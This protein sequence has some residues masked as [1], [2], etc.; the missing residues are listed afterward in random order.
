MMNATAAPAVSV[1]VR[2]TRASRDL[3][4]TLSSVHAQTFA[5]FEIIVVEDAGSAAKAR[6]SGMEQSRGRFLAFLDA[7]DLWTIDFL[8]R[9]VA[10][11]DAHPWCDAVYSDANLCGNTPLTGRRFTDVAPSAGR[12]A[13][14]ALIEGRCA[15]LLS[16]VVARR[17]AIARANGF[18]ASLDHGDDF[19][20]WLRIVN[21]GGRV[22]YQRF[23]LAESWVA[24][25]DP[26][27]DLQET[28]GVLEHF[29]AAH[30]LSAEV[31]RALRTRTVALLD[32]L[33]IE[34]A[35]R[36]FL[37]ANF[38][39]ARY[40]LAAP[41]GRSLRLSLALLALRAAPRVTR[42]MVVTVRMP[43]WRF[44]SANR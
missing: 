19:D 10:Y 12:P 20:L 14:T 40:H 13:L 44:A 37:D 3:D 16:T 43:A 6:N 15:I 8:D 41:R 29:G 35:K 11:L 25:S 7:G 39:A 24:P 32:R 42:W 1:I 28:L 9:Q 4:A 36:C 33:D 18:D 38:A 31:R 17:D 26:I 30:V 34:L 21:R 23:V 5:D 2:S 22:A 27:A